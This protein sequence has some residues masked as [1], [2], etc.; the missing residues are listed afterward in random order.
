M[1]MD[2]L[3]SI[4]DKMEETKKVFNVP[5]ETSSEATIVSLDPNEIDNWEYR[6]RRDFELGDLNALADSIE[7]RGQAQPIIV[8]KSSEI[9]NGKDK[10]K[11]PYVVIAGFRRWLACKQRGLKVEA[12]IRELSF[13]QAIGCVVSENEKESVS[14]FSKGMFYHELLRREG[15]SKKTL[16]EK[17]GM[18]RSMFNNYLS[19]AEVPNDIWQAVGDLSKVSARTSSSIKLLSQK[20]AEHHQA[21]KNIADKIAEGAGEK[22]ITQLVNKQLQTSNRLSV[23]SQRA[24]RVVLSRKI[25]MKYSLKGIQIDLK[26]MSEAQQKN[27]QSKIETLLTTYA[28]EIEEQ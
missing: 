18:K 14:D 25:S 8:V 4:K 20:S 22:V 27:L 7:L 24:T 12:I 16:F 19:F 3:N 9:F 17:L 21:I 6:D 1:S 15:V 10:V 11:P 5:E 2:F 23:N 26:G 28:Q 13:E